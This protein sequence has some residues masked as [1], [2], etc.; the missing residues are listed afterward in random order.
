MLHVPS[1]MSPLTSYSRSRVPIASVSADGPSCASRASPCASRSRL[2]ACVAGSGLHQAGSD[3]R[4]EYSFV[5]FPA[6]LKQAFKTWKVGR[7]A[8]DDVPVRQ[9]SGAF[10][11]HAWDVLRTVP[12][13]A[14]ARAKGL[15]T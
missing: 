5:A 12:A 2:A 3:Q 8:I 4:F 13:G 15:F 9:R 10:L 6:T 1:P 11:E 7:T 14:P